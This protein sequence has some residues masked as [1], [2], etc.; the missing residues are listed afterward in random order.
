MKVIR[1]AVAAGRPS[2][3]DIASGTVIRH[4]LYKSRSNVQFIMSSYDPYY[5]TLLDRRR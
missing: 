4:F 3:L 5:K 2:T 1:L